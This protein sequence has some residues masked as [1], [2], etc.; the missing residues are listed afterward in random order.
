VEAFC[1]VGEMNELKGVVRRCLRRGLSV[2]EVEIVHTDA[3]TY[4][5]LIYELAESLK[6]ADGTMPDGLRVTFAE[7]RPVRF[8]R[9]GRALAAWV[10]WVREG[11]PQVGLVRMVQDGLIAQPGGGESE[12]SASELGDLLMS[13]PIGIGR[14]RYVQCLEGA[15]AALEDATRSPLRRDADEGQDT[16]PRESSR[17]QG[18]RDLLALV[19]G[20]VST[21]PDD[22]ASGADV[23][24]A[25]AGFLKRAAHCENEFDSHARDRV[26][27]MIGD[28]SGFPSVGSGRVEFDAWEW[29]GRLPSEAR[30][31]GSG[32]KPGRLH[33]S[34]VLTGGHS[35]RPHV[36]VVGMDE[37]RFPGSGVQDPLLLDHERAVL[38][39]DLS[40]GRERAREKV[41]RFAELLAR[42]R[43]SVTFSYSCAELTGDRE[44]FPSPLLV[45]VYRA[46]SGQ[47]VG[48]AGDFPQWVGAP[49][50]FAPSDEAGCLNAADWG[51][52][53][54]LAHDPQPGPPARGQYPH[55]DAGARAEMERGSQRFTPYDG[56]VPEAGQSADPTGDQGAVASS[57]MLE[58]LGRCPLAFYFQYVL[59]VVP[60]EELVMDA[61]QWLTAAQFGGLLHEVL[62]A[63]MHQVLA[64]GRKPLYSHDEARLMAI[65][66]DYTQRYR[67]QIPPPSEAVY[68]EQRRELEKA[69]RVFLREEEAYCE[70]HQPCYLEVCIGMPGGI[71]GSA[72]D[73]ERPVRFLLPDGRSLLVRGRIDRIDRV[74]EGSGEH[75]RVWDYKTGSTYRYARDDIFYAGRNVQNVLY[76]ELAEGRLREVTG[77]EARVV[78]SGY[79]FPSARGLGHR[80]ATGPEHLAT[81]KQMLLRLCDTIGRGAFI[82]TDDVS[83]CGFCDFRAVCGD[84]DQVAA[85][86][87]RKLA[88]PGT[89]ELQPFRELRARA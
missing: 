75:Y 7:G 66:A 45:S 72:A 56:R 64:E 49:E 52:W 39:A 89:P 58:T 11:Y 34:H 84:V 51:L 65:L 2:D 6:D 81:G 54:A 71:P 19:Q 1:A 4:V 46:V 33:V 22:A 57:T 40:T 23:L 28:V 83:D 12:L 35:G 10:T 26:V 29:L 62:Y 67:S 37:G 32:P 30:V 16:H 50:S 77:G 15:I 53:S 36:F 5:P 17:L 74:E 82:A 42:L 20:V 79:F 47:P 8:S 70:R 68:S 80:I 38:S 61:G 13:L 18:L 60:P 48:E 76:L 41:E 3:G 9:P 27:D 55:L 63:Y 73:S 31:L 88:A 14:E 87:R 43:G 86:S 69:A 24:A 78:S 44:V 21:A 85:H 59:G 25:A